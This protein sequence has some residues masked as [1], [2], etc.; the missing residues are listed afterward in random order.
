MKGRNI[1]MNFQRFFLIQ[2]L[3]GV[4]QASHLFLIVSRW[5]LLLSTFTFSLRVESC[6]GLEFNGTSLF[7]LWG[8]AHCLLSPRWLLKHFRAL[9]LLNIHRAAVV[10]MKR[11]LISFLAATLFWS[12]RIPFTILQHFLTHNNM[13]L[14][15][16][17]K[18]L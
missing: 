5:M 14:A 6:K 8:P 10:P 15:N 1:I 18:V 17:S 3:N 2:R 7:T 4:W 11:F 16:I 9:R 12:L 13:I